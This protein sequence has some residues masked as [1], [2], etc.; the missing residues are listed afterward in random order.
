MI[1]INNREIAVR[2]TIPSPV[3][4][5]VEHVVSKVDC[6]VRSAGER[7]AEMRLDDLADNDVVITL[8]DNG[9]HTTFDCTGSIDKNRRPGFALAE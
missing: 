1:C 7:L 4:P 3:L 5:S 9:G 2:A 6:G 8:L